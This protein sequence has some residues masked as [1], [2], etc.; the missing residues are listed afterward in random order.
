MPTVSLTGNDTVIINGTIFNDLADCSVCCS[1][2]PSDLDHN[3]KL[4]R[5]ATRFTL[6]I[7][8]EN[9]ARWY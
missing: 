2:I 9:S 5:M 1:D 7:P 3:K 4:G 8:A 6:L